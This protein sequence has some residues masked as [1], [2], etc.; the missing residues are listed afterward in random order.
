MEEKEVEYVVCKQCETPCY[1]FDLHMG[2]IVSAF[3]TVCGNDEAD[4][5]EIPPE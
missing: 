5:F 2:K 4:E 3:C 1:Q